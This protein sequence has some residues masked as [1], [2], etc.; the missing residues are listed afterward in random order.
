MATVTFAMA[1][2]PLTASRAFTATDADMQALL[3]WAKVAY[4]DRIQK[5]FNP[6]NTPGFNP[7]NAQIGNALATATMV[8]W[9]EAEQRFKKD[10][11]VAAVP[12]PPPMGWA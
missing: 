9:M 1:S 8:A 5:M 10:G 2:T 4:A 3:D 6:D 11:S 7:T 12:T